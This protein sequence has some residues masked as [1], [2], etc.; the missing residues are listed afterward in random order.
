MRLGS[1]REVHTCKSDGSA[2]SEFVLSPR[3][4]ATAAQAATSW[5][6]DGGLIVS[7]HFLQKYL[8]RV[9]G[10]WGLE[11]SSLGLRAWGLRLIGFDPKPQV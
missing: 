4:L 7:L 9:W 3:I 8:G 10:F 6:W 2:G 1:A 11:F 5:G